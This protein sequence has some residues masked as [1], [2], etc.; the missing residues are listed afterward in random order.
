M[1]D[2]RLNSI[3]LP[4]P[5][6]EQFRAARNELLNACG[7][8][9][10]AGDKRAALTGNQH[11][12]ILDQEKHLPPGA[13]YA[14]VEK[15]RV[16]PLKIG[17]NTVGR[18][19]DNDVV[20]ADPYVS[21]RHVAILIHAEHGC[22]LHDVASKNGTLLNGRPLS[23]RTAIHPGDQIQISDHVLVFLSRFVEEDEKPSDRTMTE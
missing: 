12:A 9:T 8:A 23:G 11:T 5:R 15:D 3:H 17:I 10:I 16:Y 19:P 21:R 18:M 20:L 7:M 13:L 22:E 6:R 1:Q 14:L 4:A 2:P